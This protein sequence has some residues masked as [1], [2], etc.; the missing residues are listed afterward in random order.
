MPAAAVA[1]HEGARAFWFIPPNHGGATVR[2]PEGFDHAFKRDL[3]H[4]MNSGSFRQ[5]NAVLG[6]FL[7][8]GWIRTYARIYEMNENCLTQPDS[9]AYYSRTDRSETGA[10]LVLHAGLANRSVSKE[11]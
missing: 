7:L 9:C 8:T 2:P 5:W 10:G 1:H 3:R 6:A 4:I 11:F